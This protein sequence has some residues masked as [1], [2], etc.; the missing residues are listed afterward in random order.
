MALLLWGLRGVTAGAGSPDAGR[1]LFVDMGCHT[2]HGYEGQGSL[3]TGPRIGPEPLPLAAFTAAIRR[4]AGEM[5]AYSP[6]VLGDG[7]IAAMH[8]YLQRRRPAADA[9][10]GTFPE[11]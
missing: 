2:C 5:P 6:A 11:P 4:P 8:D 9:P 10:P 3:L 7:E 1:V